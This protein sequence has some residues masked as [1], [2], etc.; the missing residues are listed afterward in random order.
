VRWAY[1]DTSLRSYYQS[2]FTLE[3]ARRGPAFFFAVKEDTLQKEVRDLDDLR[4]IALRVTLNDRYATARDLL[5]WLT[6]QRP[7]EMDVLYLLAWLEWAEG[8]SLAAQGHLRRAGIGLGRDAAREVARAQELAA[9]GRAPEAIAALSSAIMTNGLDARVHGMLAELL[10][11]Q[12]KM[13]PQAW[14]EALATRV[15]TPND[16]RAW[17][18]WGVIQA[19]ANRQTQAV[20]SLERAQ[21]L[22]IEDPAQ[23]I[24]VQEMLTELRRMVPGGDLTQEGLRGG[25]GPPA[26]SRGGR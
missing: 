15:L 14:I 8:D 23:A 25:A 17:V 7:E 1:R 16:D 10:L 21:A 5:L 26:A 19:D 4:G 9:A 22:G 18:M 3:R 12:N 24:R 20:R 13:V 2:D 6:E 11:S